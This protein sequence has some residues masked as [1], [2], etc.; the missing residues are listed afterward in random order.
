MNAFLFRLIPAALV[1]ILLVVRSFKPDFLA[2]GVFGTPITWFWVVFIILLY[3]AAW[4]LTP[5][6]VKLVTRTGSRFIVP[7]FVFL[8]LAAG[9]VFVGELAWNHTIGALVP[10]VQVHVFDALRGAIEG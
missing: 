10:S 6:F 2:G 5:A 9:L 3:V 1:A 8:A 4:A 7:P